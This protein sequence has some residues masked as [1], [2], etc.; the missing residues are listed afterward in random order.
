MQTFHPENIPVAVSAFRPAGEVPVLNKQHWDGGQC[1]IFKVDFSDGVSWSIRIPI[2][3]QSGSQDAIIRLLQAEQ[4]VLQ[5]ISR[6]GFSWAP[7]CH[8]SS[9]TFENLVGFPFMAL[10]WIEGSPLFWTINHPPRPVRDKVLSQ[11]AMI[12]MSLIECTKENKGTATEYFSRLTSNKFRRVRNN[13]LPGI[14]EQDCFDQQSLLPQVLYPELEV[15]PFAMDHGDLA[16]M[17]IIVDSEYNIT[18]IID[19]GFASKVPLQLAGR[20]PRFLQLSELVLPPSPS[21]QEDR[22]AYIESLRSHSSQVASWMLII[23]SSEDV[24]FCHCLLESI[25]SKG[26]HRSLAGLRWKLPTRA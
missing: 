4:D 20:L 24:D 23:H 2:H 8:G 14:T 13:Q 15:A 22:K 1:R 6:K 5:E 21:L 3:V 9:F 26:M 19:W 11:V 16:P 10:S 18:G 7:K 25:I 12:Q 17:N